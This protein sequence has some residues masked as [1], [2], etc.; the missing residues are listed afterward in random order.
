MYII[1]YL[2]VYRST[3]T[4]ARIRSACIRMQKY[5]QRSNENQWNIMEPICFHETRVVLQTYP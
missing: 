2:C 5:L 4:H 1:V 3:C